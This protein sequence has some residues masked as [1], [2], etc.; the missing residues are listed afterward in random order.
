MT[1]YDSG[2]GSVPHDW[3]AKIIAPLTTVDTPSK[4]EWRASF[5]V[6]IPNNLLWRSS[7]CYK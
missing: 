3:L 7:D 1:P 4:E 6:A 2:E 5:F